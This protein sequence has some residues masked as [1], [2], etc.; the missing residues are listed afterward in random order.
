MTSS[1]LFAMV[2]ESIVI[3]FPIFHV[4]CLRASA[5][6]MEGKSSRG[7]FLKGPPDAVQDDFRNR[8]FISVVKQ[9]EKELNVLNLQAG[10]S[11]LFETLCVL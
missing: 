11:G 8:R 1:P 9:V 2:A 5:R 4:G 6:V 7:R 3:L 10:L